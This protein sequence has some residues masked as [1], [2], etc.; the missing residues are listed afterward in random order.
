M[1]RLRG[2]LDHSH[3]SG[4]VMQDSV[5]AQLPLFDTEGLFQEPRGEGSL[6]G[7]VDEHQSMGELPSRLS[8]LQGDVGYQNRIM[9][10]L[11]KVRS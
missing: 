7:S 9:I 1:H 11:Q 6:R 8:L 2:G 5:F 4:L 3:L 10:N